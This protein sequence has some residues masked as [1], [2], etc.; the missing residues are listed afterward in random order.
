MY[1]RL[2]CQPCL[3]SPS[4]ISTHKLILSRNRCLCQ[5]RRALFQHLLNNTFIYS[6]EYNASELGFAPI[7]IQNYASTF[8]CTDEP[9]TLTTVLQ[10]RSWSITWIRDVHVRMSRRNFSILSRW[11]WRNFR[12]RSWVTY[13]SWTDTHLTSTDDVIRIE[14]SLQFRVSCAQSSKISNHIAYVTGAGLDE[15]RKEK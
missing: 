6:Y 12:C 2:F 1:Q 10:D 5:E 15:N 3:A 4:R 11:T 7:M 9:V 13:L 8:L 14:H